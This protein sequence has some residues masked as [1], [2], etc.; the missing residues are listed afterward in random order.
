MV[1]EI[2]SEEPIR[3]VFGAMHEIDNSTEELIIELN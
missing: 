2:V 1:Y 3:I